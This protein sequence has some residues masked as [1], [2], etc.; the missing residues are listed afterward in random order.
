MASDFAHPLYPLMYVNGFE[1]QF[2]FFGISVLIKLFELVSMLTSGSLI[3]R[4]DPAPCTGAG[5]EVKKITPKPI[6]IPIPPR[7]CP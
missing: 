1:F 7:Y 2:F 4:G 3:P 5:M 6:S